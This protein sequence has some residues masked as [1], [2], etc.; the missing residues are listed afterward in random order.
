[1]RT[2]TA[3]CVG[4]GDVKHML[5]MLLDLTACSGLKCELLNVL[6][7]TCYICIGDKDESTC[8]TKK[9]GKVEVDPSLGR[10]ICAVSI[11]QPQVP[12]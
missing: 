2:T 3:A 8:Q 11:L 6:A 1:M 4:A 12:A 10:C 9:H 7:L 5:P